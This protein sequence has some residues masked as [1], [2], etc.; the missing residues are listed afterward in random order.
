VLDLCRDAKIPAGEKPLPATQLKRVE[1]VF[2]TAS[3]LEIQIGVLLD[4]RS[5]PEHPRAREVHALLKER[6]RNECGD[7]G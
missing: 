1:S 2:L 7:S 4:G 6:I 3:V 5:L